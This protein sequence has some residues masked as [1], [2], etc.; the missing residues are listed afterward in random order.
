[1]SHPTLERVPLEELTGGSEVQQTAFWGRYKGRFGASPV[2]FRLSTGGHLLVLVRRVAPGVQL[3]Y[4]PYGPDAPPPP[5]ADR[6]A[7]LEA[8]AVGARPHLPRGVAFLR[9]DLAWPV[10]PAAPLAPTARL[11]PRELEIQPRHTVVLD[12][13]RTDGELLAAMHPKTRY[14]IGLAARR[15]VTVDTSTTVEDLDAW[16]DVKVENDTRDGIVTHSR[17]YFR[18]LLDPEPRAGDG[19]E[20]VLF[21]ATAEGRNLG[22]IIV[23]RQGAQARYLHGASG[24]QGRNT[25]FTYALQWAAIRWAREQGATCYDLYGIP[26]SDDPQHPM[27]GLY[28]FKTGFGGERR[29]YLGCADVILSPLVYAL[30]RLPEEARYLYYKRLRRR[31]TRGR[32]TA[33]SP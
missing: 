11:R 4:V 26:P 32:G 19:P 25:M 16:Y 9:F 27:H 12:L 21:R 6:A 15:G 13:R 33:P 2:A 23:S 18:A 10:D 3:G 8:L 31:L 24:T 22:G 29:D 28:R 7:Y 5:A 1:M 20:I 14:N 30:L 17:A